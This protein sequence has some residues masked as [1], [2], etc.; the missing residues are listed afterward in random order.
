[1]PPKCLQQSSSEFPIRDRKGK[2]KAKSLSDEDREFK[3]LVDETAD[4][5]L[6]ALKIK[7]TT[8]R[9]NYIIEAALKGDTWYEKPRFADNNWFQG[10]MPHKPMPSSS[11]IKKLGEKPEPIYANKLRDAFKA[12]ASK[13]ERIADRETKA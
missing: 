3:K 1:M 7:D 8:P 13:E 9:L 4:Q 2:G 11:Q 5:I 12:T 6:G 10:L